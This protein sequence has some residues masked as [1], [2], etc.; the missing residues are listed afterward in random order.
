MAAEYRIYRPRIRGDEHLYV[1]WWIIDWYDWTEDAY[2][3]VGSFSTGAEAIEM[4]DRWSRIL[5][6]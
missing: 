2:Y 3:A 4:F 5:K 6:K 1:P